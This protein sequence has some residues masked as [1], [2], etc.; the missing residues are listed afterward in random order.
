MS[1]TA[2]LFPGQGSQFV[3][4]MKDFFDADADSRAFLEHAD[5]TLGISLSAICFDGPEDRL[6]QTEF[7]QP[8][9]F[10]HSILV[11]RKIHH[12]KPDMVAGHSLGEYTALVAA[13]ALS[14]EDGLRLVRLRGQLMQ[15]AGTEHQGTMAAIVGLTPAVL[16]EICAEASRTGIVQPANFNSPGQVV[17]SGSPEGV[18]RAMELA[19]TRGAGMVKELVVS[20]AFHSPLMEGARE[21]LEQGLARAEIR[22]AFLPVYTNVTGEP[23]RRAADIR[24]MLSRQLTQPVQW[25]KSIRNMARDGANTFCELGP[26]KVLRRLVERTVE[27]AQVTNLEKLKDIP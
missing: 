12:V 20:G 19:R 7:T 25:E 6:R 22:D 15:K 17:I 18:G 24:G 8:A 21:G 1:K 27:G 10:V 2:F 11:A 5:S 26:G 16:E 9:I 14:F 4:M 3:G 13:G 23:V